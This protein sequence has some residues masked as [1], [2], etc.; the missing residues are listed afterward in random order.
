M[1][2]F[3]PVAVFQKILR[4]LIFVLNGLCVAFSSETLKC[5]TYLLNH[6]KIFAIFASLKRTVS[7]K[8]LRDKGMRL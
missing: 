5:G 8:S 3:L 6:K 2:L 4:L 1:F 7:G